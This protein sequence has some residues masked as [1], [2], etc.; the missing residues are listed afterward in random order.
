MEYL[1]P[2]LAVA[3]AAG[4]VPLVVK[5]FAKLKL[6][7]KA[8]VEEG[9]DSELF[10]GLALGVVEK[11]LVEA[12]DLFTKVLTE[13]AERAKDGELD[14]ADRAALW[15]LFK[16]ESVGELKRQLASLKK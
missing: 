4:L 1:L 9:I 14:E 16:E 6:W 3:V 11:V 8:K 10:E 2:V 15:A 5:L 13:A 7:A 12:E